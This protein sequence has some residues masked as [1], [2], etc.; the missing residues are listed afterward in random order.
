LGDR[1]FLRYDELINQFDVG[2]ADDKSPHENCQ[3]W[4]LEKAAGYP[5]GVHSLVAVESSHRLVLDRDCESQTENSNF[6]TDP[7]ELRVEPMNEPVQEN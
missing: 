6:S 2:I 5:K 7:F 1:V 3:L 4:R